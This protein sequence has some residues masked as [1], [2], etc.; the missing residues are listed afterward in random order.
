M[1]MG[2]LIEKKDEKKNPLY[3]EASLLR[4]VANHRIAVSTIW[5][6]PWLCF[7]SPPSSSRLLAGVFKKKETGNLFGRLP[8]NCFAMLA[9]HKELGL[10]CWSRDAKVH[11]KPR[12][13]A[14]SLDEVREIGGRSQKTDLQ[15]GGRLGPTTYDADNHTQ[16]GGGSKLDSGAVTQEV[17]M[18]VCHK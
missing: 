9:G 5:T 1:C 16:N 4:K 14:I 10:R 13:D 18:C 8:G 3:R 11:E 12:K 7:L 17:H 15:L 2:I 6:G